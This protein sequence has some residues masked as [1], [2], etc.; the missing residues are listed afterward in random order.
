MKLLI[1]PSWILINLLTT[2]LP[3]KHPWY[4][5]KFNLNDWSNGATSLT[6]GLSILLW[7]NLLSL[8]IVI[9]YLILR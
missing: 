9:T 2:I 7:S 4:K 6:F 8:I 3:T 1:L 5:R